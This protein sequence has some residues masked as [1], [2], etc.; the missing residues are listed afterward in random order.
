MYLKNLKDK[1]ALLIFGKRTNPHLGDR[2]RA[3]RISMQF[4]RLLVALSAGAILSASAQYQGL[5][6]IM[7]KTDSSV[8]DNDL[9]SGTIL[10]FQLTNTEF[11]TCTVDQISPYDAFW[12]S[13]FVSYFEVRYF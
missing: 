10:S 3:T 13:S 9:D 8:K 5:L 2:D 11:V 4:L 7:I 6:G 12:P 1:T